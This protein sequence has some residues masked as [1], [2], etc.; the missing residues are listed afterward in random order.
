MKILDQI[1][2]ILGEYVFL[3]DGLALWN[4]C[5]SFH[6]CRR[7]TA[8]ISIFPNF[9]HNI[10]SECFIENVSL[11]TI[12]TTAKIV[13]RRMLSSAA[14]QRLKSRKNSAYMIIVFTLNS[15]TH[16]NSVPFLS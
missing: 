3:S 4:T 9:S 14:G 5:Q 1:V 12:R 6:L 15:G 13:E 10:G 11:H 8:D 7:E 2:R 16:L